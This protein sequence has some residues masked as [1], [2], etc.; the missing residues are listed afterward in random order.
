MPWI[1][2]KVIQPTAAVQFTSFMC[3]K[4]NALGLVKLFSNAQMHSKDLEIAN[5][6]YMVSEY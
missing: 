1:I 5:F 3:I 6:F 2:L 4:N